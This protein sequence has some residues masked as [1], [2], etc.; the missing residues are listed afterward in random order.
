MAI[1]WVP[2]FLDKEI[3]NQAYVEI[4]FPETAMSWDSYL[5]DID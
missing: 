4:L 2:I 1:S 3:Q 5:Q